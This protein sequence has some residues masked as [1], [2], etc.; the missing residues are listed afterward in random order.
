LFSPGEA[1]ALLRIATLRGLLAP[2]PRLHSVD[3]CACGERYGG[4]IFQIIFNG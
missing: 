1:R 4:G 2:R 3:P